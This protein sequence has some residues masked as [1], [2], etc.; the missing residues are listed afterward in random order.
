MYTA[1]E[2][3]YVIDYCGMPGAVM[4]FKSSSLQGHTVNEWNRF[5]ALWTQLP[6]SGAS[7]QVYMCHY[8]GAD[9]I[10]GAHELCL[11]GKLSNNGG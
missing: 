5:V 10:L 9:I 8:S 1:N 11:P 3:C 7:R 2:I 6:L 4:A